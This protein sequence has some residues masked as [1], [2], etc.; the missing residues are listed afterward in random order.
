MSRIRTVVFAGFVAAAGLSVGC[1]ALK[2]MVGVNGKSPGGG[3]NSSSPSGNGMTSSGA[4]SSAGS[5]EAPGDS[6]GGSDWDIASDRIYV[7]EADPGKPKAPAMAP[8]WCKT[9]DKVFGSSDASLVKGYLAFNE[10]TR[11]WPLRNWPKAA[12]LLCKNPGSANVKKQTG[13]LVQLFIN[14]WDLTVDEAVKDIT[15]AASADGWKDDMKAT[16]EALVATKTGLFASEEAWALADVYGC[17]SIGGTENRWVLWREP[18]APDPLI[19]LSLIKSCLRYDLEPESVAGTQ[20]AWAL[21]G[22]LN[23]E[24]LYGQLDK[25]EILAAL[26]RR[27]APAWAQANALE[28]LGDARRHIAV[29]EALFKTTAAKD[30]DWQALRE[31]ARKRFAEWKA[32]YAA[33]QDLFKVAF[34]VD[35]ALGSDSRSTRAACKVEPLVGAIVKMIKAARPKSI[36]AFAAAVSKPVI[37]MLAGRVTSCYLAQGKLPEAL[38]FFYI[39][40][41]ATANHGGTNEEI[42]FAMFMTQQEL[43]K[44]R[45]NALAGV[46]LKVTYRPGGRVPYSKEDRA[47]RVASVTATGDSVLVKFVPEMIDDEECTGTVETGRIDRIDSDGTIHYR[48]NC[49]G[50]RKIKVNVAPEPITV[51]KRWASHL[52][53]GTYAMMARIDGQADTGMPIA[54]FADKAGKKPLAIAGIDL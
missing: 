42:L 19:R 43:Q 31:A 51:P 12:Q 52:A 38:V 18:K 32:E 16:C 49:T 11:E 4:P 7:V 29:A 14:R 2:G 50:W 13:Y 20:V 24:P 23:C 25:K 1:A 15:L 9:A 44:D 46:E 26:A 21:V 53:S 33:N 6:G 41:S 54:V 36:D 40:S 47:A 48:L 17:T 45:D 27:K 3:G 5:S 22:F 8:A 37:N 39:T 34:A 28:A 10:Q 35:E 30:K